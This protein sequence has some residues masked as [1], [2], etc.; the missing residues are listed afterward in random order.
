MWASAD[1][2]DDLG[3]SRAA[4]SVVWPGHGDRLQLRR[5]RVDHR[6]FQMDW[7]ELAGVQCP[8][9]IRRAA[10]KRQVE[11]FAGR[12]C[13]HAALK[14]HGLSVST[15]AIGPMG[16]PVWPDGVVGSISHTRELALAG[17]LSAG[18]ANGFGLDI[19]LVADLAIT[20]LDLIFNERELMCL[21]RTGLDPL[22]ARALGFS[23]KESFFKALAPKIGRYFD[24]NALEV[25]AIDNA[26][27]ELHAVVRERLVGPFVPGK[28]CVFRCALVD[29]HA[30]TYFV[31]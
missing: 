30:A 20:P 12:L 9:A 15:L 13:A 8:P 22:H 2:R 5:A 23:A 19:E 18:D 28:R 21:D 17:V 16:A 1:W 7:F 11:F 29:R 4:R 26:A 27:A 25:V 10:P 14:A 3:D 24:F 31:W 6:H